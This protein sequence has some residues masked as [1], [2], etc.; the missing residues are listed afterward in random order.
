MYAIRSYYETSAVLKYDV[1]NEEQYRTL[2]QRYGDSGFS[3]EMGRI[4]SYNVCYT[5]LLRA[6]NN[7]IRE[8]AAL[9]YGLEIVGG[10]ALIGIIPP[11]LKLCLERRNNE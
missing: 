7:S 3:A 10:N 4:T 1:L 11:R 9:S 2:V 6:K 8:D 5:K